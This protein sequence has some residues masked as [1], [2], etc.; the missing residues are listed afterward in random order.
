MFSRNKFG[1]SK[2]GYNFGN[3]DSY[4]NKK[5]HGNTFIIFNKR[6]HSNK[7]HQDWK[8]QEEDN[9]IGYDKLNKYPFYY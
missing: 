5:K 4:G 8:Y 9:D 1:S 2:R 7:N 3:K 6:K